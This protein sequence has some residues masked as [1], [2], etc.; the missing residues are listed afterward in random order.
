MKKEYIGID[1][2]SENTTIYSSLHSR[3]IYSEPTA[4]AIDRYSKEIKETGFLASRIS[5]KTPYNYD[6]IHPIRNGLVEDDDACY[7]YLSTVLKALGLDN[8]RK[9]PAF[10]FAVNSDSSKVNRKT[11]VNI[12]TKLGAKDIYFESQARLAALGAGKNVFAPTATM[13]CHIGSGVTDIACLS[14]GEIVS[15]AS[16]YVAGDSFNEAIRRYMMQNQHL[17]IGIKSAENLKMKIG[18]LSSIPENR[19]AE[20]KG[21]D[22]ITSLPSSNVVSSGEIR[23]CLLPLANVIS[24]KICDV[25]SSLPPELAADLTRDGMFLS[26]GGALIAGAKDYFQHLLSIPVKMV[27]DPLGIINEGF[28]AYENIINKEN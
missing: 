23:K 25:I 26:G 7:D 19:L 27:E 8:R 24:L 9:M 28:R 21:R 1:L 5:G 2:G 13:I 20:I 6:V 16:T 11:L 4:I 22:T 17:V 12:A 14:L 3:V 15:C 18:S 10:V